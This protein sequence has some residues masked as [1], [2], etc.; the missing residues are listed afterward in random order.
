MRAGP[1]LFVLG[2]PLLLLVSSC[3][4]KESAQLLPAAS[5]YRS[6]G[7]PVAGFLSYPIPGHEDNR[8]RIFINGTGTRVAVRR[9]VNRVY[10][11]YPKG[12]IILKEIFL[13]LAP[14]GPSEPQQITAMIKDPEDPRSRVGW[15]WVSKMMD[16][17]EETV[18]DWEFC[19]DCHANANEPHPYGDGNPD[20][21]FRDYVFYPYRKR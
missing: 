17:G 15:L 14:G 11:D 21:E 5:E 4:P 10:W 12:T 1:K 18:V 19:F 6:W 9:E 3:R 16:S 13:G 2:L 7:Q 8:R 20:G